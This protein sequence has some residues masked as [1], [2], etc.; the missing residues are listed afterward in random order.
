MPRWKNLLHPEIW[1]GLVVLLLLSLPFMASDLDL[2]LAGFFYRDGW[3]VG[4]RQPWLALYKFGTWPGLILSAVSLVALFGS[5]IWPAWRNR[6]RNAALVVLTLLIAPGLLI[7]ALGK[8]FWGRPRPRDVQAFQGQAVFHRFNQPGG[9]G[10]GESFPCG[11]AS[12]GF[13]FAGLYFVARRRGLRWTALGTGL[14]YGALLGAARM[15]QGGH[16]AS[17]VLWSGGLTYLTAAVL[18]H[19]VLPPA[20]DPGSPA[21]PPPA[22][23]NPRQK[24][25]GWLLLSLSLALLTAFFLLASPFHK[26]WTGSLQGSPDL[27]AI[28][29]VLP[30]GSEE[31]RIDQAVQD[32]A[33]VVKAEVRGFGFPKLD[34]VGDFTESVN[35]TTLTATLNLRFNRVTTERAGRITILVRSPLAVGLE[36]LGASRDF[37]LGEHSTPGRWEELRIST[38]RGRIDFWARPGTQVAGPV[39]LQTR[40]GTVQLVLEDLEN[41]G[42]PEWDLGA[43]R[44]TVLISAVQRNATLLPFKLRG[45]SKTGNVVFDG[46]ISPACGLNLR[47]EEGDG[48]SSL[49]AKGTWLQEG[50]QFLGPAG[51][52]R[53]NFQV[54][55]TTSSGLLGV[56]VKQGEGEA[57][58]AWPTP[59]I[60]ATPWLGGHAGMMEI[61]LEPT[62]TPRPPRWIEDELIDLPVGNQQ[63]GQP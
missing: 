9:P 31:I 55:L 53:P 45:W 20:P 19:V 1:L 54:Y 48:R 56:K 4:D 38:P 32:P 5:W 33:L 61:K 39:W 18:H 42:R 13:L 28:H 37:K 10:Q 8:D 47:W 14:G 29:L 16:F 36:A 34:L 23:G 46:T 62:P 6:R 41:P 35:G 2:T 21:P 44:G 58:A 22:A 30:P 25:M 52:G 3:G 24:L 59:T 7:N 43:E 63:P 26:T 60:T 17:D 57:V 40:R 11:H 12:V 49:S 15:A 27:S 51:L 50:N